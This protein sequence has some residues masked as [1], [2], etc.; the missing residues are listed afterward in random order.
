MAV[1]INKIVRK[2]I[3]QCLKWAWVHDRA[4]YDKMCAVCDRDGWK[5]EKD[6]IGRISLVE[7]EKDD[8]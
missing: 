2:A 7:K 1:K 6:L 3:I 8:Q 5:V 4:K